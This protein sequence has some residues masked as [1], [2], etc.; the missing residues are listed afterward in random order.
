MP[1][2]LHHQIACVVGTAACVWDDLKAVEG[3]G[4]ACD[5]CVVNDMGFHF[6]YAYQH[7]VSCHPEYFKARDFREWRFRHKGFTTHS[8]TQRNW[9]DKDWDFGPFF[10]GDSVDFAVRVMLEIG[11]SGVILAGAPKDNSPH[12][13]T[14]PGTDRKH[15]TPND[16]VHDF[17][18]TV[19]RDWWAAAEPRWWQGRVRAMSGFPKE[20]SGYPT[21]E[22]LNDHS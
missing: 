6:P 16:T 1:E 15:S 10:G 13:Y 3:L 19:H 18:A 4:V 11:Y 9:L 17:S 7:W 21:E 2:E 8:I 12:Y 20:I 14:R 5:W 22:W